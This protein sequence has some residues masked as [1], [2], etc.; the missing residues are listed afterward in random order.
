MREFRLGCVGLGGRGRGMMEWVS[1][2]IDNIRSKIK[3][4]VFN[5]FEIIPDFA[6]A[7]GI[8][9][10]DA[11]RFIVA[12]LVKIT[13][14][15]KV[16]DIAGCSDERNNHCSCNHLTFKFTAHDTA[17]VRGNSAAADGIGVIDDG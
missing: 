2:G 3:F 4:A 12:G 10:A 8:T 17:P 16:I 15:V 9:F 5:N 14:Y 7:F 6:D 13:C 1:N 11:E